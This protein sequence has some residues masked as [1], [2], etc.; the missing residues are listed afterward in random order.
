MHVC[1][2]KFWHLWVMLLTV[3]LCQQHLNT[4]IWCQQDPSTYSSQQFQTL[5][6]A[7]Q[8]SSPGGVLVMWIFISVFISILIFQFELLSKSQLCFILK[9][10][11]I[12]TIT[13]LYQ[14][15]DRHTDRLTDR[16]WLLRKGKLHLTDNPKYITESYLKYEFIT[17]VNFDLPNPAPLLCGNHGFLMSWW[18]LA[19]TQMDRLVTEID[20]QGFHWFSVVM[21]CIFHL[22]YICFFVVNHI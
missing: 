20:L 8:G 18:S 21:S 12:L 2:S 15:K 22:L 5:A 3:P 14:Q 19:L 11:W 17:T 10:D 6:R 7:Y 1:K 16:L 13:A 4:F 9:N